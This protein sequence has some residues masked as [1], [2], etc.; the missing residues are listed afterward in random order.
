MSLKS[1][2][3]LLPIAAFVFPPQPNFAEDVAQEPA[4]QVWQVFAQNCI[5]CHNAKKAEGGLNL[6][7]HSALMTGGDS[8]AAVVANDEPGSS[9]LERVLS[10]EDPM[11]PDGNAVGARRLNEAEVQLVRQWIAEGAIA[12]S[13]PAGQTMTLAWQ[14][15]PAALQPT[16]A[17]AATQD[18]VY[19]AFGRGPYAVV[20]DQSKPSSDAIHL[21]SDPAV[22]TTQASTPAPTHHDF[23]NSMAFSP[24]SQRL[25][26]GGFRTVKIWVR[27][28]AP[29]QTVAGLGT[30]AGAIAV[31]PAGQ[32]LAQAVSPHGLELTNITAGI[33]HR[34]LSIH[35]TP[36]TALAWLDDQRLVSCD[37]TGTMRL[38]EA[39]T[40]ASHVVETSGAGQLHS[41]VAFAQDR[42]LAIDS[43]KALY[44]GRIQRDE[45]SGQHSVAFT[46]QLDGDQIESVSVSAGDSP[47]AA[48]AT[49]NGRL[50][51]L[52]F[53]DG[54]GSPAGQVS[55]EGQVS[56]SGQVLADHDL[57]QPCRALAFNPSGTLI[58]ATPLSGGPAQLYKTEDGSRVASL[59]QDYRRSFKVQGIER[60]IARQRGMTERLAAK[61]PELQKVVEQQAE[62][63]KKVQEARDKATEELNAKVAV[64]DTASG[65]VTAAEQAV[66]S[67]QAAVAEAMKLV[68]A[69][70]AELEAKRKAATDV[71]QQKLAATEELAKRDQALATAKESLELAQVKVPEMEQRVASEKSRLEQLEQQLQ[72]VQAEPSSIAAPQ[73]VTFTSDEQLAVIYSD[74]MRFFSGVNGL[75]L[76]S[77]ETPTPLANLAAT[78][79]G[80]TGITSDGTAFRWKAQPVWRLERTLGGVDQ[81]TFSD[82]ITALAFSPDG[83]TLAVGSGPASRFGDIKLWDVTSGELQ[84]YFGEVHSDTVLGLAFSPDGRWL[85][86]GGADKLCRVFDVATGEQ[87][88]GLEG[89]THHVLTVAWRDD[90]QVLATGSADGTIKVWDVEPSVQLRTIGGFSKEVTALQFVG[91]SSE[92]IVSAADGTARL[93]NADNGQV[94]RQFGGAQNALYTVTISAKGD[95]IYAA[96]QTGQLWH[97]RLADGQL[98]GT[99]SRE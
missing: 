71:E 3:L 50:K 86:S 1:I 52:A 17:V 61:V 19:L 77:L 85:A 88:R 94:V 25:A 10:A 26:T 2:I 27:D 91:A 46:R 5:A 35:S 16:Y 7:S 82:R 63:T 96:G 69:R 38:T 23:V 18:G 55:S 99:L 81:T 67:A 31:A 42:L 44:L 33:S 4:A 21:L 29:L 65:E 8:G 58:V 92:M 56:N 45:Q 84:R 41:V 95:Q 75:A 90:G 53:P 70:Q 73:Q 98:L 30:P 15:L 39:S 79:S 89:H 40:L 43:S 66:A 60:S 87:T 74:Q 72:A 20:A 64:V 80:L 48:V 32:W 14:S 68:E 37:A 54:Q 76:G 62:A 22:A 34:L 24:D 13:S 28:Q 78:A 83:K 57:G 59:E 51:L 6:E 11:P 47:R 49:S 97:W 36:I 12:P 93:Y 9:L